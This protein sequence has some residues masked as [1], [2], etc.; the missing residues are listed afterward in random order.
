[1]WI[2]AHEPKEQES[3][4]SKNSVSDDHADD[5]S[6]NS[7]GD[8]NSAMAVTGGITRSL[9]KSDNASSATRS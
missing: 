9:G 6:Y 8:L 3:R 4:A 1:M 2:A 5:T 7:H